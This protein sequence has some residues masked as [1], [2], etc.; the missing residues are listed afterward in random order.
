MSKPSVQAQQLLLP[1]ARLASIP[2]SDAESVFSSSKSLQAE[3]S[4]FASRS[5][6]SSCATGTYRTLT[7]ALDL[8]ARPRDL[9]IASLTAVWIVDGSV[10]GGIGGPSGEFSSLP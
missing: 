3:S 4:D 6:K 5:T 1:V 2:G 10:V 7:I 8:T 9:R